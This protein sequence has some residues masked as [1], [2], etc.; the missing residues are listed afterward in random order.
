MAGIRIGYA[1]GHK[2]TIAKMAN[3]DGPGNISVMAL[4]APSRWRCPTAG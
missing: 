3:W 1:I 2:D 4:R